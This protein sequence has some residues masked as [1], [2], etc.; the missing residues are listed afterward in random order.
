MEATIM[1]QSRAGGRGMRLPASAHT[2]QP[3]RIHEFTAGFRVEDVWAL[4]TPGGKDDFGLLM[5][6]LT[7]RD[8]PLRASSSNLVRALWAA[9]KA[10][11][12]AFGWDQGAGYASEREL[13]RDRLPADLAG[14]GG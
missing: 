12:R 11:G 10:L 9:R 3:W 4:P 14:A 2:S 13:L 5:R 6:M 8:S 7:S 1:T